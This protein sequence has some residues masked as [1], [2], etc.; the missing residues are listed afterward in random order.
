MLCSI[1]TE[2]PVELH[3]NRYAV[4]GEKAIIEPGS[5]TSAVKRSYKTEYTARSVYV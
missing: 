2:P 3:T 4:T 5:F 1:D